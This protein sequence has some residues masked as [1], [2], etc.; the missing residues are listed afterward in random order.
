MELEMESNVRLRKPWK[1]VD[2]NELAPALFKLSRSALITPFTILF[3]DILNEERITVS[4]DK[5]LIIRTSIQEVH[6][7]L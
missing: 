5:S 6:S 4:W 7:H 2:F 1:S 3:R